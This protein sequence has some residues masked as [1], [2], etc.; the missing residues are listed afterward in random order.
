MQEADP[1]N[2]KEQIVKHDYNS[3]V[4]HKS[5]ETLPSN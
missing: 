1:Q 4:A 2:P 3:T 5:P